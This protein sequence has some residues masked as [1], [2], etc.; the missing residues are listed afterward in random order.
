MPARISH[1]HV[2]HCH[3]ASYH[4]CHHTDSNRKTDSST[5]AAPGFQI[6]IHNKPPRRLRIPLWSLVDAAAPT[7]ISSHASLPPPPFSLSHH[8]TYASCPAQLRM[9]QTEGHYLHSSTSVA[10]SDMRA[11]LLIRQ[12]HIAK[13]AG[14]GVGITCCR[15]LLHRSSTA[16][17]REGVC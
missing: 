9:V 16:G 13:A 14:L 11:I 15:P 5:A 4:T 2:H 6:P 17:R 8:L 1:T 3:T 7:P 10:G 12:T